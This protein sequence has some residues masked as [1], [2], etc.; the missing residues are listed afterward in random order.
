MQRSGFLKVYLRLFYL[1]LS[2]IHRKSP[3]KK[4]EVD[5]KKTIDYLIKLI[6]LSIFVVNK[7]LTFIEIR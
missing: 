4:A 3:S 5:V 1:F 2:K 6:C 7:N